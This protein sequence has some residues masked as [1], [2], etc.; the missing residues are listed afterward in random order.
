MAE[1]YQYIV[2]RSR[3]F[4]TL[5]NR[6]YRYEI[7]NDSYCSAI[8][9]SR[10][11]ILNRTVAEVWG[12]DRFEDAIKPRLDACF[13]GEEVHFVEEFRFG[14]VRKSLHVSL[15]PYHADAP[16]EFSPQG[17]DSAPPSH[18]LVFSHDITYVAA[19]ESR[20]ERYEYRDRTTGLY[21]RRS[22]EEMLV[23]ELERARRAP[24]DTTRALL[25]VSLHSFKKI[26]QTYGHHIGDLLLENTA[27]RIREAI[28]S[29]D[30]V[31][32]FDGTNLVVLLT[33]VSHPTDAAVV[34]QKI[35]DDVGVPYQ[36]KGR[37]I[38]IDTHIGVSLHPADALEPEPLIQ[39]ANS[40]SVEAEERRIP[41]LFHDATTH[42]RALARMTTLSDLHAAIS[43]GELELY[44]H[45]IVQL[46]EGEPCIAGAEALIRWNH[47]RRGLLAPDDFI[48]LAEGSRLI[49]AIDK[50]ALFRSVG[51]LAR[52]LD[53]YDLFLTLNVS[54]HEFRDEFLPD[55]VRSALTHHPTVPPDRLKLE[56]TERRSME[57][58]VS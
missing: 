1:T 15:Y 23:S 9:R 8:E 4:I 57:D 54:A 58:P 5:I 12:T 53:Q 39:R 35:A 13:R 50:W 49:A 55:I 51:T 31:F 42:E 24:A 10:D 40:A 38:T 7:V 19:V 22:L 52:W 48:E 6:D 30:M 33:S 36:Y 44:Y 25:F 32:R 16:A 2:N 29:S 47:P 28:R 37:V 20:L 27:N 43:S 3:D 26:N 41:F 18:V 46:T 11:E 56:L 21:N 45:P 14:S 17:P 34:A